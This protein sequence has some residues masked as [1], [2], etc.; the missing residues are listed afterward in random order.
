MT[1]NSAL[2]NLLEDLHKLEINTIEKTVMTAQ[3][4]PA[5]LLS[6]FEIVE[7][8][9]SYFAWTLEQ[10][11]YNYTVSSETETGGTL[12]ERLLGCFAN[13]SMQ[14]NALATVETDEGRID[15][16]ICGRIGRSC[17]GLLGMLARAERAT[18]A[19]AAAGE[20]GP[21]DP[22]LK[23]MTASELRALD[24]GTV[25]RA[26]RLSSTDRAFLRKV[27]E[28]G[29]EKVLIQTVVQIEGDVITRISPLIASGN[30][31]HLMVVHKDGI[32]TSLKMWGELVSLAERLIA[33]AGRAAGR[34]L[35]LTP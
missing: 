16:M 28:I 13:A 21:I 17:E 31:Q 1:D 19:N 5:P 24:S 35:G 4:M 34:A 7:G 33:A 27:W 11:T 14:F 22:A 23:N 20:T 6:V 9:E 26:W 29:T 32:E 2:R 25:E 18:S 15:R 12:K 3:K 10:R 8:Y 30:R